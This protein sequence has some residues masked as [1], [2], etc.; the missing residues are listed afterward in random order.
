MN[1]V[2]A[3]VWIL[4]GTLL[5]TAARGQ[6]PSPTG[7]LYGTALDPDGKALPGVTVTLTG[8]G[9]PQT[10]T[11]RREGRLPFS[12]S[13]A[14]RL[15]RHSRA[16]GIRDRAPGRRRW[17]SGRTRCSTVSMPVAGAAEAVTVS[18]DAPAAGQP[19][20][21][22]RSHL[23]AH[24]ARRHPHDAGSLGRPSPGSRSP[25]RQ[26]ST[27]EAR[28]P[29]SSPRSSGRA[30]TRIRTPTT[31]TAWPSRSPASHRS[32]STSTRSTASGSR[33]EAP[34]RLSSSPGVT[35]NL[36]TKRGTNEL[37]GSARGLY[38]DGARWDYGAEV[39]GPLW[40][41]RLWL[42]AAGASNSYLSQTFFVQTNRGT[43]PVPGDAGLLECEAQRPARCLQY[44]HSLV[45]E[46]ATVRRRTRRGLG[47]SLRV[48]ALGQHLSRRVVPTGGL[49]GLF[50][51]SLRLARPVLPS[52]GQL[53]D[54]EERP[55][56]AGRAGHIRDLA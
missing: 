35:L 43:R 53:Q 50:G 46:V 19:E 28:T 52:G 22:D 15:R 23:L 37:R 48:V 2:R 8:P 1:P 21:G 13:V 5:A 12:E 39:G 51:E 31:S 42:W 33:P 16:D 11:H 45:P 25:A 4:L 49:T 54:A 30:L 55:R 7:N 32:F 6:I 10:V 40:K 41:D 44:P 17:R 36:V 18:G 20:D 9:A 34:T 56:H 3:S 38:T 29:D 26:A 27:P 24:G 47:K 14:G